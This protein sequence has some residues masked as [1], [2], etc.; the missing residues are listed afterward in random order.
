M[1]RGFCYDERTMEALNAFLGKV[2]SAIIN[3]IVTVI[4]LVAFLYFVYGV[5]LFIKNAGNEEARSV[6]RQHML[7]GLIGLA[8]LFGATLIMNF[9]KSFVS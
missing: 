2:T 8:I 7:W 3:P 5:M 6:G 4:A 9:L 1:P